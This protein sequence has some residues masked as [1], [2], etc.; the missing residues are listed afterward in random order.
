MVDVESIE[1][2][3][4]HTYTR[5]FTRDDVERFAELSRDDGYHHLVADEDG[6]V[7]VHGLLTATLPTK[8]GGDLDY[9]ARTM[10]FEFPR[11][12]FTGQT[13]TCVGTVQSYDERE[14][15]YALEFSF[16]CTTADGTVVLRGESEGVVFKDRPM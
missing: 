7:L 6:T 4:Q 8:L 11:P 16:E 15:R 1:P 10:A 3:T 12:V 2:G 5:T 9:V 14:D 13:V